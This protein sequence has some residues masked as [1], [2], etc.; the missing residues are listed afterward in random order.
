MAKKF[1]GGEKYC[2]G[3]I[4]VKNIKLENGRKRNAN[5]EKII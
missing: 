1:E 2:R 3:K 4:E 5:Q